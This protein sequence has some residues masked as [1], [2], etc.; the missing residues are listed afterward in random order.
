MKINIPCPSCGCQYCEATTQSSEKVKIEICR[1]Y[2]GSG[3]FSVSII[4]DDGSQIKY[5]KHQCNVD[6]IE[7]C[8]ASRFNI[9]VTTMNHKC[10][11]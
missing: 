2:D 4:P 9:D 1:C 11:N 3:E 10:F 5:E 7:A 8:L 6:E